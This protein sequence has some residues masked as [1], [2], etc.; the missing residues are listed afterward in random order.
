MNIAPQTTVT[1]WCISALFHSFFL[2]LSYSLSCSMG[3]GV[4]VCVCVC[5]CVGVC[6]CVC[7]CV[8]LLNMLGFSTESVLIHALIFCVLQMYDCVCIR[9]RMCMW[10]FFTSSF[11]SCLR[12]RVT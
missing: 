5:V 1:D 4:C 9:M 10:F 12:A 2:S 7:V 3:V 8:N 6:V 11:H